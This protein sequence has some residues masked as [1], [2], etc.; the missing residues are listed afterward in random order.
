MT[1]HLG[2]KYKSR[3]S[4]L[5][6][7]MILNHPFAWAQSK[8]AVDFTSSNL[9]IVKIDTHGQSIPYDDPRIV[10]DMEIIYN[11][12][13]QRNHVNDP[14]NNYS[15]KISME[16]HGES[17]AGWDKKSY[18]I[19]T[20]NTDGSNRNVPLIDLPEENDWIL[21]AP[22]YDR[23]L[24]RNVLTYDLAR[25][26]GWYAPRTRYCELVLNGEYH[27]L[28]VLT[29]KIKRDKNRVNI[30]KLKPDEISGDDVTG[31]Y[32]LRIDKEPWKDGFDSPYP[33]FDGSDDVIRYQYRYPK[34]KDLAP[35]QI[36]YIKGYVLTFE[37][38][39]HDSVYA[40][41]QTGYAKYLNVASFVD[42]VLINELSRNV[43]GYRL[44][45]YFYKDKDSNGGRLT[46]GPVW[47]YNFSFGNAGYYDSWLTEGWQLLYFADDT[48]F[49]QVDGFFMPFWWKL[50]FTEKQF[51]RRLS[52]RWNELRRNILSEDSLF[53]VIDR[54]A[55]EIDEAQQRN[56][57]IWPGPGATDLGGGWFPD[58][59]RHNQI[60][61]YTDEISQLKQWI[62]GR[63]V[64]VDDHISQITAI[65]SPSQAAV[66]YGFKLFQN[67]PNPFNPVTTIGYRL[68]TGS[69]VTL[70]I[71]NVLGQK[72]AMLKNTWQEAGKYSVKFDASGL[73][74]GV[75]IYCLQIGNRHLI[76]KMI[77]LK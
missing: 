59:P 19:E 13:D 31:G 33:P 63:M 35:E 1:D 15:G 53:A 38:V 3:I 45:A 29:E 56:F 23:S 2:I 4:V 24:M 75:Y 14:A 70:T 39:M 18:A 57:E 11:G 7:A 71:H 67:Y 69:R 54:F 17:S 36:A 27:G 49:H 52:E 22:Y 6:L 47:D 61:S 10:A 28:Y 43:D 60:H 48:Y 64:W 34:A 74:S 8:Q 68:S 30:N 42:Y 62:S 77:L 20:Q 16:I 26:M 72:V 73:A 51:A 32:I 37:N 40:D 50:L 55:A 65:T 41:P 44:S 25:K 66:P 58:D 76:R 5:F 46:A 9:P 12:N 21:Y